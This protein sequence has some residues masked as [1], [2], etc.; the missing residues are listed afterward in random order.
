MPPSDSGNGPRP[1]C[2]DC[3]RKHIAQAIILLG[4]ARLGYPDHKWLAVGHLA[5]ASEE[6]LGDY[7]VLAADIRTARLLVMEDGAV[8]DL[9][10]LFP[11]IDGETEQDEPPRPSITIIKGVPPIKQFCVIGYPSTYGGADTELADQIKVWQAL[12][13][14]VNIYPQVPSILI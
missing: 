14:E 7:P 13:V 10:E 12:G 2:L 6:L 1:S 3:A 4:E 9:M 11:A 5:E 8:P